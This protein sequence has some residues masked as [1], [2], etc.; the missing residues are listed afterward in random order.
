MKRVA[1][2]GMAMAVASG[3]YFV[4]LNEPA[5]AVAPAPL[6]SGAPPTAIAAPPSY[7]IVGV[8]DI[9]MGSDW[10]LPILDPRVTPEGAAADVVGPDIA[11]LIT[12][13]DIAFGNHEGTIHNSEVGAKACQNPRVCFT[14][15]SPVFHAAY[16]AK[17]GFDMVSNANNHARDFGED[18]RRTTYANLTQAGIAV[19]AADQDGLRLGQKVL[20]DGT[21]VSLLAFGHNPG[22]MSV[23]NLARVAD[24][25]RE[26]DAA[27]DILIVSCHIGAEGSDHQRVTRTTEMFLGENRG[28]PFAFA[29]VAVD[30]G[31]DIVFCHGPHVARAVEVYKGRFIAYS[32][33]NF[34]T[35]GRFNLNGPNALA[36]IADLRVDKFGALRAARIVSARQVRPGGPKLDPTHEAARTMARLTAE[37]MPETGVKI[38]ETGDVSW[39]EKP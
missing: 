33:G 38:S 19:S 26:A 4:F 21:R 6:D 27:A 31:A 12:G 22:L 5:D 28:N 3:L 2:T 35:Y 11:A 13:A 18:A 25:V 17:A 30:A 36:P 23:T 34:W 32:L 14:F 20:P 8:G 1:A 29:R 9:M 39:P 15:R 24:L 16:L 10:P 37:D 7:R